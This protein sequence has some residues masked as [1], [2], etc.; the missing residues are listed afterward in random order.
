MSQDLNREVWDLSG[1]WREITCSAQCKE[2]SFELRGAK[3]GGSESSGRS[4]GKG[5][6]SQE[7]KQRAETL[8]GA[9]QA[10]KSP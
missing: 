2:E 1:S 6:I 7:H 4:P 3:G 8:N 5:E 9:K 10:M